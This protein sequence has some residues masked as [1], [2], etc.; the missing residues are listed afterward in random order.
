MTQVSIQHFP[1]SSCIPGRNKRTSILLSG[2]KAATSFLERYSRELEQLDLTILLQFELLQE[3]FL[4]KLGSKPD[5][6]PSIGLSV[7]EYLKQ[8]PA[9]DTRLFIWALEEHRDQYDPF[10]SILDQYFDMMGTYGL[11]HHSDAFLSYF[12]VLVFVFQMDIVQLY[13]N[14]M[15]IKM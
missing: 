6:L 8:A 4:E 7:T 1:V 14:R 12:D 11:S 10:H 9:H 2:L 5:D 15:K 13:K 3:M